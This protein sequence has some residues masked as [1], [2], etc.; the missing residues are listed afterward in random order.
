MALPEGFV[1][2]LVRGEYDED[3]AA[4]KQALAA[5]AEVLRATNSAV[6][7][8]TLTVG[9]KVRFVD[10]IRPKYLAGL[11]ATVA[12]VNGKSVSVNIDNAS[13]ARRYGAGPVRCPLSLVEAI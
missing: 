9:S 3:I 11:E 10:S 5:R 13:S 12:K 8:A 1:A 6:L 7:R 2:S 4:L